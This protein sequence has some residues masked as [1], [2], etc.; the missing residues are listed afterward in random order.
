MPINFNTIIQQLDDISK[1][2]YPLVK[3]IDICGDTGA[4]SDN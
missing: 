2:K 3:E 1:D 4:E